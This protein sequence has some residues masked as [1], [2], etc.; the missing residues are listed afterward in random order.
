MRDANFEHEHFFLGADKMFANNCNKQ[1]SFVFDKRQNKLVD[2]QFMAN[3]LSTP[4]D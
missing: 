2:S 3:K 4:I 1:L